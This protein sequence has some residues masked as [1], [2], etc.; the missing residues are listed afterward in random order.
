MPENPYKIYALLDP[1]DGIIRYIGLCSGTLC[2]RLQTHMNHIRHPQERNVDVNGKKYLWI[3]NL[4]DLNSKPII[5]LVEIVGYDKKIASER[6]KFYIDLY[7]NTI[8]NVD[9]NEYANRRDFNPENYKKGYY[10]H[11]NQP[12]YSKIWERRNK[13]KLDKY[14]KDW[15]LKNKEKLKAYYKDYYSKNKKRIQANRRSK[16]R[17]KLEN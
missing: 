13:E 1:F 16:K 11:K 9:F 17:N 5:K 14:R 10:Y 12:E 7:K 6:E 8:Y 4:L 15:R 2:M 3:K